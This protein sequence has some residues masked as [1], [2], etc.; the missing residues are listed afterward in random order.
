MTPGDGP[1]LDLDVVGPVVHWRGPAPFHFVVVPP[2]QSATLHDL[3]PLLTYGWGVLP[4][5]ARVGG[6]TF[7]T[8]LFPRDGLYLVPLKDAVRRAEGLE[9]GDVVEL[10]LTTAPPR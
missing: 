5:T 1:R 7:T 8:S 9:L 3:A 6:T 4:V 10:R 2:E